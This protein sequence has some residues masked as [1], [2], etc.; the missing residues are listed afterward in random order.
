MRSGPKYPN[1]IDNQYNY[2]GEPQHEKSDFVI[3]G[4][5]LVAVV[6]MYFWDSCKS[7]LKRL[8]RKS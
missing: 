6:L 8:R 1:R 7:G 4:L 3:A 5:G 2:D